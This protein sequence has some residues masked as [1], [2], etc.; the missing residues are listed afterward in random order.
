V[1]R[2]QRER[3]QTT[4]ARLADNEALWERQKAEFAALRTEVMSLQRE[5]FK[6]D[7]QSPEAN[8]LARGRT[9]RI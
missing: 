5:S 9:P 4:F 7:L 3:F 6:S 2:G 8:V 1:W